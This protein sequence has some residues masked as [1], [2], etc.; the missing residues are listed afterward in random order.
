MAHKIV[1]VPDVGPVTLYKRKGARHIRLS[2]AGGAVRVSMPAWAPYKLGMEFALQRLDWI[3]LNH[4]PDLVLIDGMTIG[5]GH[6]LRFVHDSALN[7]PS[8][9]LAGEIIKVSLPSDV[10]I[11]DEAAQKTAKSAAYRA[12]RREAEDVLPGRVNQIADQLGFTYRSV[13]IRR[14][15]G[16]WGSCTSKGELT[17]NSYLMQLPW[18]L[19]DYVI[20]HELVHT[21]IMAHGPKFWAEVSKYVSDVSA[22]R[23]RIKTYQPT[24]VDSSL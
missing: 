18:D 14:L 5:K 24:L 9:R 12:L 23:K 19:I 7:K 13:E 17:F 1:H 6:Q 16:R 10:S 15:K 2:V 11:T 20:V 22:L 3:R 8:S 4:K 21:R